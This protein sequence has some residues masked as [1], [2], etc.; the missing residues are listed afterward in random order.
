MKKKKKEYFIFIK[1]NPAPLFANEYE[2]Y[3]Q[4]YSL[5]DAITRAR[6]G[7]GADGLALIEIYKNADD[8]HKNK[9][10]L[11]IWNPNKK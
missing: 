2:T 3:I 9:K 5:K 10:P 6:K 7:Y 1:S 8:F 11:I 4:S